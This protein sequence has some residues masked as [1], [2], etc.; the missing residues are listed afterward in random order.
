MEYEVEYYENPNDNTDCYFRAVCDGI[1]IDRFEIDEVCSVVQE[2][3]HNQKRTEGYKT[4]ENLH[5]AVFDCSN[6][7]PCEFEGCPFGEKIEE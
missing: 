3:M 4:P 2:Y 7:N 1:I 6:E 5:E